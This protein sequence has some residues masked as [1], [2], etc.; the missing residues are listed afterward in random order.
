MAKE[1]ED[2][3][4]KEVLTAEGKEPEAPKVEEKVE[5][6]ATPFVKK[7][8][9]K[10]EAEVKPVPKKELTM[11]ILARAIRFL[12]FKSLEPTEFQEFDTRYPEL[13]G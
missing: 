6:P 11:V 10:V 5:K 3:K 4:E 8:E 7:E 2:L 9:K 1:K 12:A 13:K